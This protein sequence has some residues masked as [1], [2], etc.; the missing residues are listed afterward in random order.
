MVNETQVNKGIFCGWHHNQMCLQSHNQ[1]QQ[2][3]EDLKLSTAANKHSKRLISPVCGSN[4]VKLKLCS[5]HVM[6]KMATQ[7]RKLDTRSSSV[8]VT[9]HF[10]SN[11]M[12]P[13]HGDVYNVQTHKQLGTLV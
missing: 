7:I 3:P 1:S 5:L 6:Y 4:T 2:N 9:L 8:R 10:L 13:E 11:K 12:S